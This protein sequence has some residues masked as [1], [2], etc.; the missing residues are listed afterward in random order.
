MGKGVASALRVLHSRGYFKE[1]AFY[2]RYKDV[3]L[4]RVE[5]IEK[6]KSKKGELSANKS[7]KTFNIDLDYRDEKGRLLTKKEAYR[8][9]CYSFH[10]K[11]PSYRKREADQRRDEEEQKRKN[12]DNAMESIT[13]KYLKNQQHIKDV[14]YVILQG[15]N[16]NI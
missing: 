1:E 11:L 16:N 2:G 4:D 3:G 13:N 15:K 10:N 14:P 5:R 8:N 6:E 9:L 7:T 12:K